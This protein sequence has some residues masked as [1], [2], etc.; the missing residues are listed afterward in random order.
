MLFNRAGEKSPRLAFE[1]CTEKG[2]EDILAGLRKENRKLDNEGA[3]VARRKKFCDL[4][5]GGSDLFSAV[6]NNQIRRRR[7]IIAF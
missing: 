6:N 4:E 1:E 7:R 2:A 5:R 3:T